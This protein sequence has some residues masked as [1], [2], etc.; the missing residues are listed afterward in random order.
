MM[1]FYAAYW[2]HHDLMDFT[3]QLLRHA[4]V[5][6]TGSA[7]LSYAGKPVALDEPFARLSVQQSLVKF[8]GLTEAESVAATAAWRSSCSVKSI[9]SWWFQ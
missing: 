8:A 4:A 5:A 3:E 2:N 1:E 9:R 7:Q 6:A